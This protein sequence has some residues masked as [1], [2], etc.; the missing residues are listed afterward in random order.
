M[1]SICC[2]QP[3][4]DYQELAYEERKVFCK[5]VYLLRKRGYSVADAQEV[6]YR[7]IL[8]G[9]ILFDVGKEP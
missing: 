3:K 1:I 4:P 2:S 5:L 9:S 7:K 6:A 8:E